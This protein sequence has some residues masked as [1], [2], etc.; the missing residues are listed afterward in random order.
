MRRAL[1]VLTGL[2]APLAAQ[3]VKSF[4]HADTLRGSNGPARAW[5][6]V[7]FYD[8][9]VRVQPADSTISGW[10]GIAYRVLRP[11]R[12]LQIDLQAPLQIDTILQGRT[13]L[14]YRPAANPYFATL[15][16]MPLPPT[17]RPLT[18]SY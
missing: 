12:E 9:H 11:A 2:A 7:T 18:A 4:T 3:N 16:L 5:W 13:R 15:P 8:L 10:N 1:L 6:D 17:T 14:R